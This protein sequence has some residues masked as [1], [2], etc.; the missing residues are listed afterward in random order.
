MVGA[1]W[2]GGQIAY[3]T[4]S[5]KVWD[6]S[7]P[8][9]LWQHFYSGSHALIYVVDS[10]DVERVDKTAT[11]LRAVLDAE[12]LRGCPVLVY[13]NKS[14]LPRALPPAELASRLGLHEL[15]GHQW[16]IQPGCARSGEGLHEG[17]D[18]VL[19]ALPK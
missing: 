9:A 4:F 14:D 13:A 18:W 11:E 1:W 19:S 15:R 8:R 16:H 17:L 7:G 2:R 5:L 6:V 12:E 10:G 3:K